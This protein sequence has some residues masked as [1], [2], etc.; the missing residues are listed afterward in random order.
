MSDILLAKNLTKSYGPTKAVDGLSLRIENGE[1]FGFLGPN[2]AGKTTTIRMLAGIMKPD[3]GEILIDGCSPQK[4][5]SIAR[6]VGVVPDGGGFYMW[7]TANEYLRFFA[8]LLGIKGNQQDQKV[9]SLLEEVG[10]LARKNARIGTYSRGMRQ[11]LAIARALLNT[12]KVLLLDEPT[13]GLDPQGQ[14]DVQGL[15]RCL[16]SSGVTVFLS[17]H[18]L[19]EVADLCSR[20]GIINNGRLVAEGTVDDLREQTNL[21]DKTLTEVFLH[22][23]RKNNV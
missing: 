20:I 18:L 22:I 15:L 2:G 19:T 23:T 13:V 10:L 3:A 6:V 9:T 16:N 8:N 4:K 14:E 21:R 1:F 5:A 12:P 17:S 11:R 7:M